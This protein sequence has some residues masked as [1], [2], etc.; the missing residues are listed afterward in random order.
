MLRDMAVRDGTY[1]VGPAVGRL[2]VHTG[3]TGLGS[4]AGHDLTIGALAWSGTVVV[5]AGDTARSS[6]SID[7]DVASLHVVSGSGGVKPLTGSDRADIERIMC[8]KILDAA[9]HPTIT[10]RSTRVSGTSES[11]T[12]DGDLTITDTS[13]PIT[14]TG[15]ADAGGR[16]RATATVPQSRWGIKPYSAFFGALKVADE[17][18][19]EVEVQL[20]PPA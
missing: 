4:R 2:L 5:N 15:N 6:V 3:R 12:V 17:V 20:G 18:M 16:V 10:F 9:R 1:P 13:R 8:D 14:A 19:I 11:F 7:V